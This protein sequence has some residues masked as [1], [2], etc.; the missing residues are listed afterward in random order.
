MHTTARRP[1]LQAA[2][3][4]IRV[5]RALGARRCRRGRRLVPG[6]DRDPG[7]GRR[8][9]PGRRARRT[10]SSTPSAPAAGCDRCGATR[11]SPRP[12]AATRRTWCA[13]TSSPTSAPAARRFKDRVR[14]AG[15]GEPGAGL[16]RGREPRLG[17]PGARDARTR[18]STPGSRAP[19]TAGSCSRDEYRELGVGVAGGAPNKDA[20]PGRDLHDERGRDRHALACRHDRIR[21]V[22]RPLRRHLHGRAAATRPRPPARAERRLGR[23]GLADAGPGGAPAPARGARRAA[24]LTRRGGRGRRARSTARSTRSTCTTR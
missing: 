18:S 16:A 13:A 19:R 9:R 5:R 4:L 6:R 3:S 11:T 17:H 2:A 15:Y 14:E 23:G 1:L 7:L 20:R 10:A 21:S 8:L 24:R 22:G 12:P